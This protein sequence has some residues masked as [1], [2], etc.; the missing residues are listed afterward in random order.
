MTEPLTCILDFIS[1]KS[2]LLQHSDRGGQPEKQVSVI[3]WNFTRV[4]DNIDYIHKWNK[5]ENSQH[6]KA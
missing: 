2:F 4:Y 3:Y 5:Q 6:E 1:K